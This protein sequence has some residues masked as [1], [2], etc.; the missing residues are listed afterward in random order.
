MSADAEPNAIH[1]A[2]VAV[3]M[4][5]PPLADAGVALD[6][7]RIASVGTRADLV[8]RFPRARVREWPGVMTPGLVNA[9]AH[10]EYGPPF[11]DLATSALPFPEWIVEIT[12]RRHA[13]DDAGWLAAARGSVHELLRSGTTCVADVV[14]VGAG[15]AAAARAGLA[16]ISYVEAVGAD[17]ASAAAELAR[18]AEI[19][20]T[21]PAGRAL[22]ISPHALYSLSTGVFR[23]LLGEARSRGWRVHTHLAETA[24]EAEYV[25]TGEGRFAE[26]WRR[27]GLDQDLLGRGAGVSP[28][29]H[30]D[31]LG[32]LGPDVHLA[33]GVHLDDAD[34]ALL[35]ARRSYV[36]LCARSNR[37]L[38]AGEPPVAAMLAEGVP[39]ANGTDSLASSPSLD[40]LAEAAALHDIAR[41]QGAPEDGLAEQLVRAATRGGAAAMG[42][43]GSSGVLAPGAR[44][45]LAVFDV[46]VDGSAYDALVRDGA[47]RCVA[48]VMSGRIVHR[49]AA[50]ART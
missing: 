39:I 12:R 34:R 6:G 7:D 14:T 23:D 20:R 5:G 46:R 2:D 40:L 45:D 19:L 4:S 30:L 10:L 36:A 17:D 8:A 41:R 31:T 25:R 22:G 33:H 42:L 11:A 47:G 44:A 29:A 49:A 16:G 35:R 13:M 48:T 9:H 32:G 15:I 37:I 50:E 21:A 3:T 24:D 26:Q 43:D 27:I 28:A 38:G 18:V 1:L